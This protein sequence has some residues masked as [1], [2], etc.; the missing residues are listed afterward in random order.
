VCVRA[1]VRMV[2]WGGGHRWE[3]CIEINVEHMV[4]G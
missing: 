2:F 3:D 1:C 4:Q